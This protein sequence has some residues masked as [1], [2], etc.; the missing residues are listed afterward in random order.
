M[1]NVLICLAC[2]CASVQAAT[3]QVSAPLNVTGSGFDVAVSATDVFANFPGEAVTGFGF[4]VTSDSPSISFAS[5][6]VN[7]AFFDDFSGC[8][9]DAQVVGLTNSSYPAGIGPGDFTEPLVLATLHFAVSEP[10]SAHIG[11]TADLA[12]NPDQG[13]FFLS[14]AEGFTASEL[15]TA[16]AAPEPSTI[17]FGGIGVAALGVVRLRYRLS[18]R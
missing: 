13:L 16:A 1:K 2:V 18:R 4:N 15:V 3:I 14:G 10:G 8:C 5:E 9:V 17:L 7:A 12:D 6:T 11:V